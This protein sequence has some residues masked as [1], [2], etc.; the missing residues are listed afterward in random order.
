MSIKKLYIYIIKTFLP[1]LLVSFAISWF[2]VIMQLLWRFVD[3]LVGK[4]IDAVIFI[5]LMFYAA[6]TVVPLALILAILVASLMTFGNL[7]ERLELLA[8]KSAGVPLYT[9]MKPI[10]MSVVVIAVGLFVF[11]NDWMIKSQVKFWAYY[12]AIRNKS[13]E[14]AIPEGVFY[15][16][17]RGYSIYVKEK[18]S[19]AKLLKGVMIYD[20][21]SGIND[22]TVIVADSGRVYSTKDNTALI[23]ELY[24]GESFKNLRSPSYA[25]P[26]ELIPYLRERFE[27]KEV[28]ILFDTNLDRPD[29]DVIASQF[30]GKNIV[31]LKEFSDSLSLIVDSLEVISAKEIINSSYQTR[32]LPESPISRVENSYSMDHDTEQSISEEKLNTTSQSSH[33]LSIAEIYP[34]KYLQLSIEEQKN[35]SMTQ[36]LATMGM[37]EKKDL[38]TKAEEL[39]SQQLATSSFT[40]SEREGTLSTMRKNEFEFH[41]KM[42]YPVA[43]LVFFFIGAPLGAI[44]RKG[45][46]GT[47]IVTA[48]LF[49]IVYYVLETMG[50]KM[51]RDGKIEVWIGMWLPSIVLSPIG[52]WLSYIATKD[53]TKLNLDNYINRMRKLLGTSTA[54]KIEFKD[55]TMIEVNHTQAIRDISTLEETVKE[56]LSMPSMSYLD[57]FLDNEKHQQ[58]QE[59]FELTEKIVENLS[60]SRDYLLINRLANYPYLK[61]L[62]RTMRL[63]NKWGNIT[64]MILFPLGLSFYGIYL[65]RNKAYRRELENI[66]NTNKQ[67][68]ELIPPK[69]N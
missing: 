68:L 3:D 27:M 35:F 45:G 67:M 44:I 41:R 24:H 26:Q 57:F 29:E 23:L 52:L 9:I 58:R 63:S 33:S 66:I 37:R 10:F 13:P 39:V 19:K 50:L 38:Y 8:M 62:A 56:H 2:V 20:Y 48:V 25:N 36:R 12:F 40:R 65:Y 11:Q 49:F 59:I 28:H 30:V 34:S 7:G 14:L 4:G 22:A 16:E 21:K 42:T 43:C 69:N 17:L 46:L 32:F 54:R 51:A 31:Q 5:K 1:L 6:M 47:P 55:I 61:D 53:S 60:N 64:L 15:K 18:D